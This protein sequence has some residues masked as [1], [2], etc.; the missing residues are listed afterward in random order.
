MFQLLLITIS[1]G[2]LL[3]LLMPTTVAGIISTAII[4]VLGLSLMVYK[5]VHKITFW[6]CKQYILIPFS[7]FVGASLGLTF[8]SRCLTSPKT[9]MI[10]TLLHMS[11]KTT[12]LI[13]SVLLAVLS[14]YFIYAGLQMIIKKDTATHQ[15]SDLVRMAISCIIAAPTTVALSQFMIDIKVFSMGYLKFCVGAL[16][17]LVAILFLYCLLGRIIPSII[18][19]TG[20]FMVIST[21]NVYVYVFRERLFEPVDVF[22]A[23]TAMNVMGNYS[24]FPIPHNLLVGWAVFISMMIVLGCLL[25]RIKPNLTLIRRCILFAICAIGFVTVFFYA[26]DV[27]PYHWHKD[28]AKSNGYIL[29]FVSKFKEISAP[30]PNN[31][32][33]ELIDKLADQYSA[34]SNK[35][36]GESSKQPHIIAI[37]DEAF[38]DL[39]IVG[40]F[41]TNTEVMPFISSLKENTVSGYALASVHGGNTSNSEYEFLTG[42]S[43]AWLSPSSVPYQQYV[44]SSTYSMVSYLKSSYGYRCLAMH[45]YDS[46]GWNRPVAYEHLGF[47]ECYFIEDFPQKNFIREYVSDQE[48]FDFLIDTYEDQKA[49]PLFIFGVTMQN[50]GDYAYNGKNFTKHISLNEYENKFPA[51]EQYLSL[52]HETD[53]AVERLITYFQNVDEDVIIVFF[54]DHQP[55]INASFYSAINSKSTDI[56]DERQKRYQVPFF[57][58]SNYDIEEKYIDSTSLN[59]LS[60]YVYDAAGIALPPYNQFLQKMED[61]IP[62]INA[63]GFYSLED[64]CYLPFD[65]ANEEELSWLELYEALQYNNVFDK[66]HRNKALFPTL[67]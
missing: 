38:S 44:R 34:D 56:L 64:K 47:D 22:S 48:M 25:Y 7:I 29:D 57:I 13:G 10:A 26:S 27:K 53:K 46:D 66:S 41:S 50:H 15:K 40:E 36:V 4:F 6:E 52:I 16:I 39:S 62:S 43:M 1:Y 18:I 65:E 20:I 5:K 17:V 35:P 28:G 42:N 21:I 30:K 11:T 23:G 61:K 14:V 67:K 9:Q 54:G 8:Y 58:W 33:I 60:S 3:L 37:M 49:D 59:Y 12:L 31:Y 19:G 55:S 63:N 51:V 2:A 32:S 24:L 45:P